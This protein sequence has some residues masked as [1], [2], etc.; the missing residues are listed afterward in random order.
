MEPADLNHDDARLE[1]RLRRP[2]PPIADGGFSARVVAALPAPTG[3]TER[4][5]W[6]VE[7]WSAVLGVVVALGGWYF[8]PGSKT[9]VVE[10]LQSAMQ[11]AT[12]LADPMLLG[13]IVISA[14]CVL[15]A[16][17]PRV[18]LPR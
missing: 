8:W 17:K 1:A 15:F 14:G 6:L 5:R 2:A 12:A 16:L 9:D 4:L 18:L 11:N 3:H 13:A 10:P 7:I